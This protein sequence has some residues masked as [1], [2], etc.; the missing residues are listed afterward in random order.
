MFSIKLDLPCDNREWRA[1]GAHEWSTITPSSV[2]GNLKCHE[3]HNA[4]LSA[5]AANTSLP[6]LD[7]LSAYLILSGLASI[8]I[9]YLQR[10]H[11]PFFGRQ[12]AISRLGSS[13]QIVQQRLSS[14][15]ESTMKSQAQM[16]Y[17][18]SLISLYTPLDDLERA[19]NSGYSLTG[20]T[21]KQQTRSAIV[22]LLTRNKVGLESAQHAISLLKLY[23]P[24]TLEASSPYE[25]SGL[26]LATLTLWAYLIGQGYDEESSVLSSNSTDIIALNAMEAGL[27]DLDVAA[28]GKHW[29]TLVQHVAGRLSMKHNDNAREYSQVLRSLIDTRI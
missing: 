29:R 1:V 26:Y 16:M 27:Q 20:L 10:H 24:P 22:R 7:A 15:P 19:A 3:I 25:S 4:L 11:E 23:I 14:A 17:Y 6:Y 5:E 18:V 21:P 13:L 2:S 8:T 12:E 9:D 28:C